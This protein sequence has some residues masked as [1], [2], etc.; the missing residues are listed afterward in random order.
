MLA[1]VFWHTP[2]TG[3]AAQEYETPLLEFHANLAR[4][5]PPGLVIS[6]TYRVSGLPWLNGRTGYEDWCLLT[7]TAVLDGLNQAFTAWLEVDDEGA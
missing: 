4:N 1:Y 3:I 6:A 7:S 5:P 2:L